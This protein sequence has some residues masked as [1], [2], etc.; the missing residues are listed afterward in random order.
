M[1][2]REYKKMCRDALADMK[3]EHPELLDD[4]ST[5]WDVAEG[6]LSTVPGL[7]DYLVNKRFKGMP[8]TKQQMKEC[9]AE[10]MANGGRHL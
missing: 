1:T 7:R 3:T 5:W 9:L 2:K 4:S 6:Q 10:D 8:P